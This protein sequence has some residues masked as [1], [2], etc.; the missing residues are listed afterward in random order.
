MQLSAVSFD[1][2]FFS[3]FLSIKQQ[4]QVKDH[5]MLMTCASLWRIFMEI[6]LEVF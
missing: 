5:Y 1:M 6:E 4:L 2:K 3:I